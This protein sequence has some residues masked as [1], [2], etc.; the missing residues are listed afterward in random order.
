MHV[1]CSYTSGYFFIYDDEYEWV[2]Y[3]NDD[4]YHASHDIQGFA[5]LRMSGY[6]QLARL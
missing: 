1:V 3:D 4:D 6:E 2:D 5:D